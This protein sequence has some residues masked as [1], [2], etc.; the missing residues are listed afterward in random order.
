M[1]FVALAVGALGATAPI[2]GLDGNFISPLSWCGEESSSLSLTDV[3]LTPY[4]VVAGQDL[5]VTVKGMLFKNITQGAEAHLTAK[6]GFIPVLKVDIDLCSQI[7][8]PLVRDTKKEQ[9]ITITQPVPKI[10]PRGK[11]GITI[12][13]DN[14]D[15]TEVAC[16]EGKLEI[17]KQ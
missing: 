8:C 13:V 15:G 10:A 1:K 6:L 5:F 14:G 12:K 17:V 2:T 16:L 3:V 11:L 4:P 7:N 9:S